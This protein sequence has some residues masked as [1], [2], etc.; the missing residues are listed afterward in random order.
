MPEASVCE[1]P[2]ILADQY[3]FTR[4]L[5][6]GTQAKVYEAERLSDGQKVAIKALQIHSV[7]S[8]KTYELFR[9]ESDVLSGLNVQGVAKFYASFE[10]LEAR[11]AGGVYC[12]GVYRWTFA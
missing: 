4:M 10:A 11:Y 6:H 8:W 5:G 2:L 12:T 3:R 7:Q 9:R 1:T